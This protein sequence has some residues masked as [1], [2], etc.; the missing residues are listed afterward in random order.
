MADVVNGSYFILANIEFHELV[1]WKTLEWRQVANLYIA[2]PHFQLLEPEASTFNQEDE[3]GSHIVKLLNNC[4][5]KGL[6]SF[7]NLPTIDGRNRP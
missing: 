3:N 5:H 6:G 7:P 2:K 4:T 1:A